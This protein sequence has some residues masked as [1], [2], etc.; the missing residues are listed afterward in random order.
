[1]PN[2]SLGMALN[3]FYRTDRNTPSRISYQMPKSLKLKSELSDCLS[4]MS[5]GG[6]NPPIQLDNFNIDGT[7]SPKKT[8]IYMG[9]E[10]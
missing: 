1:M 8:S 6:G 5:S 10:V 7:L 4:L 2:S 3:N 9:D